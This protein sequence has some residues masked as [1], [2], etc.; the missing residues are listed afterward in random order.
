V[1]IEQHVNARH[2]RGLQMLEQLLRIRKSALRPPKIDVEALQ[3]LGN[4]PLKH[5]PAAAFAHLEADFAHQR[6]HARFFAG[7]H[8]NERQAR[9]QHRLQFAARILGR[10]VVH[11]CECSKTLRCPPADRRQRRVILS[12]RGSRVC[13]SNY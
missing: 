5:P 9:R 8:H 1:E 12:R 3:A 7:L 11:R 4:R 2:R 13:Q 6:E 10:C